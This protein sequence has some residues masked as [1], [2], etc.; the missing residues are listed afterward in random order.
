MIPTQFT[1]IPVTFYGR[2]KVFSM[3]GF[4]TFT[5]L[6]YMN[7]VEY[8]ETGWAKDKILVSEIEKCLDS[9]PRPDLVYAVSVQAHGKYPD[10]PLSDETPNIS[11]SGQLNRAASLRLDV[12]CQSIKRS[13]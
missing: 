7:G 5:P 4:D 8:N 10:K 12:L 3:L 11:V 6:E 2:D 9:S 1:I 13:G